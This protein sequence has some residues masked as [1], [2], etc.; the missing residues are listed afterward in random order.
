MRP[1]VLRRQLASLVLVGACT[2]GVAQAGDNQQPAPLSLSVLI[3][4]DLPS[5]NEP[6][7]VWLGITNTTGTPR[8]ICVRAAWY[9]VYVEDGVSR[10]GAA[11]PLLT[12]S[13]SGGFGENLLPLGAT[14]YIR[15]ELQLDSAMRTQRRVQVDVDLVESDLYTGHARAKTSVSWSGKLVDASEAGKALLRP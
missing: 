15:G 12:H 10:G 2:V 9:S 8:V 7:R 5:G 11:Q 4:G 6:V 14:H 13:C 3:L 1:S